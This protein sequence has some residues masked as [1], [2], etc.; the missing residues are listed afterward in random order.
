MALHVVDHPLVAHRVAEL[1]D[2]RTGS[3]EFRRV[4]GELAGFLAYEATRD[5]PTVRAR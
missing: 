1:R 5:L 2:V 4:A 3:A